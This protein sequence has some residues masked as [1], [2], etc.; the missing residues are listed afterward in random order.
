[1]LL[2]VTAPGYSYGSSPVDRGKKTRPFH[3]SLH[4]FDFLDA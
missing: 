3:I 4:A 1:M 2:P